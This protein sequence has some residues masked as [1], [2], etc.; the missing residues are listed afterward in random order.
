M[1]SMGKTQKFMATS[2]MMALLLSSISARA[3]T[4]NSN[5]SATDVQSKINSAANG[6]VILLPSAG[7][8]TWTTSVSLPSTKWVTLDGNGSRVTLG[9]SGYLKINAHPTGNNR[10]T[11]FTFIRGGSTDPY[12]GPVKI[13]DD[14]GMAG[15]RLDHCTFDAGGTSNTLLDIGGTGP[16]VM[17]HCSFIGLNF[18]QE[19]I[20][21]TG[22]GPGSTTG[23]T[24]D[25][26][27]SLA[28][29]GK[30]F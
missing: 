8:F 18:A 23:W 15:I 19:F 29:S 5:G 28:G 27:D 14:S 12:N 2:A 11:A 9:A 26:G 25:T 24:K 16:G 4:L 6:D 3:A 22:W 30:I 13:N 17:D 7:S 1:K 20:H 21:V 10:V